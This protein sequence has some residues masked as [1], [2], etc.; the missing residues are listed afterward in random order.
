MYYAVT[1]TKESFESAEGGLVPQ[2]V[3]FCASQLDAYKFRASLDDEEMIIRTIILDRMEMVSLLIRGNISGMASSD[4]HNLHESISED[5]ECL[6]ERL[7]DA[8]RI[9]ERA[10]A[11]RDSHG[12]WCY[13]NDQVEWSDEISQVRVRAMDVEP[14]LQRF[15]RRAK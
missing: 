6:Q 9:C 3:A 10:G 14:S 8:E 5:L 12:K 15:Y 11:W 4:A 2:S 13:G 7:S 1:L